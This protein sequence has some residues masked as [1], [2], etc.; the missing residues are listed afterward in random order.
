MVPPSAA[1]FFEQITMQFE[2]I[3]FEVHKFETHLIELEALAAKVSDS[4]ASEVAEWEVCRA[5]TNFLQ[6]LGK[7]SYSWKEGCTCCG[8]RT[9]PHNLSNCLGELAGRF[10]MAVVAADRGY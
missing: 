9:M 7:V 3:A 5:R 8:S 4:G 10:Q 6:V 1:I 2:G